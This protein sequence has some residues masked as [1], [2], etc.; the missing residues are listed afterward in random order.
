MPPVPRVQP[1]PTPFTAAGTGIGSAFGLL[2]TSPVVALQVVLS[3]TDA[4][5][6]CFTD[7]HRYLQGAGASREEAKMRRGGDGG[8]GATQPWFGI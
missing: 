4:A 1:L 5:F 3:K 6:T 8:G 2:V 7:G